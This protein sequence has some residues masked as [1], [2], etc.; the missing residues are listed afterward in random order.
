[1]S[2]PL[3]CIA[4]LRRSASTRLAAAG[5]TSA[6]LEADLLLGA[7]AG[8]ERTQLIAWPETCLSAA[9][10]LQFEHLIARRLAGEPIAYLLGRREFWSLELRVSPA[11]LIPRPETETLVEQALERLP[12]SAAL[13]IADLG[14]GSGAIAAALARERPHW[15]LLGIER[16]AAALAVAAL[17]AAE[18]QL[19]NLKLIRGDW[20][21]TLGAAS[22]DAILSNPPY[23]RTGDPHLVE[24]DVRFEPVAAL[25]SGGDGLN[26]I[27]CIINDAS[28][29]L[30]PGGLLAIEH[31]WD[32]GPSLRGL[33]KTQGFEAI[34]TLRDL[35][36]QER[37]TCG[38]DSR[39]ALTSR[40]P[41][42][43]SP[44]T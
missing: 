28:R 22:I 35:A 1:M 24:G 29:C 26:A 31:G 21:S 14:T 8:L 36:G 19:D 33:M 4:E 5:H 11:T 32:Q 17:N 39:T 44:T 7:A 41:T 34:E 16:D 40:S 13:Q 25:I 6:A 38:C 20:S 27:R 30:R 43:R 42:S 15:T 37:V 2:A 3:A 12:A 23:V 18:L 10:Q 9:Q